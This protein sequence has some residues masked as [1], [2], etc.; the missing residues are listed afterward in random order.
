MNVPINDAETRYSLFV[1]KK[2][3]L[4]F[5]ETGNCCIDLNSMN[6]HR[7]SLSISYTMHFRNVAESGY[8][9]KKGNGLGPSIPRF[10]Q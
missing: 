3:K 2:K 5:V 7:Y 9:P 6:T 4:L 8:V 1:I 10:F